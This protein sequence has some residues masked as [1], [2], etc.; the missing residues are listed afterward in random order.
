MEAHE[1]A[2]L[3]TIKYSFDRVI[4]EY[5]DVKVTKPW[6]F[7][8]FLFEDNCNT[9]YHNKGQ[10]NTFPIEHIFHMFMIMKLQHVFWLTCVTRQILYYC[11]SN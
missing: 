11:Q 7:L 4:Q 1:W 9:L 5:G 2:S 8:P 6:D 3:K 10:L